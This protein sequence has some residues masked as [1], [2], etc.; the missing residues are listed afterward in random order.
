MNNEQAVPA[1]TQGQAD[2]TLDFAKVDALR[3]HMLLTVESMVEIL[4]VSRV[5]YYN[6]LKGGKMRKATQGRIRRITRTLVHLVTNQTWP[7]EA[8]FVAKQPQRLQMLK[9]LLETL[10]K[11]PA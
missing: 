7:N 3:A 2:K 8:V 5:S 4:G 11:E 10:D 6:W 9:D 1:P